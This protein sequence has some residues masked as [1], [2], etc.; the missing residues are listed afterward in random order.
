MQ[1]LFSD[2]KPNTA[3]EW[4]NQLLK[5]LKGESFESLVWHNENGFDIQPFYTAEDLKQNYEP[6]FTHADW[7]ICVSNR[8]NNS[9]ELNACFL[10]QLNAGAS[11]VS[12]NC[13]GLDLELALKGIQL[14]YIQS[15]FFAGAKEAMDLKS[16]LEKHYDLRLLRCSVF[17]LAYNTQQDL[18]DW[19]EVVSAFKNY[20]GIK[21][22]SVNALPFHNQS[23]LAHYEVALI[24][25]QLTEYLE[26]FSSKKENLPLSKCVVKTG[27]SADYFIQMAKLRAIRRLWKLLTTEYGLE[28]ELHLVVETSLTNKSI[29]DSYN[30]LL[31]TTVESMAAISGGCNELL[32]THFDV[33]FSTNAVLAERMSVNQQLILKEESYFDKMADTACGSFYIESITDTIAA[34]ALETFKRFEKEGGYF[35]CLGKGLFSK[36]I[37]VQAK[38]RD[39]EINTQK[40]LVIGV[41]KFKNEKEKID[42][43]ATQISE[44]K[45]LTIHNPVLHYELE[46]YFNLKNA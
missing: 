37:S 36:E 35:V 41:N 30:N 25:S 1:K 18:K 14:N 8:S 15:T 45:N 44:L 34:K 23:C 16:Y 38:E 28:N 17:P 40:K 10:R 29:S 12:L 6:A 5:D 32:V 21:T 3:A 46:H 2:F 27:V 42:L 33:L 4:K 13:S 24:L 11:S 19:S 7:E 43:S 9:N 39:E 31:R 22:L 26:F 20:P